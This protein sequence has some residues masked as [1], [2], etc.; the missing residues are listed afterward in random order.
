MHARRKSREQIHG[1]LYPRSVAVVGANRGRGTVPF[2][3]FYSILRDGFQGT[4]FPVSP[5]DKSIA[6]VKAYKYVIDIPDEI[7]MAVVVFPSTVAH[8]AMEQIGQKGIQS[9][10]IISAG[11]REIGKAGLE[12]EEEVRRIAERY[13]VSFIGPN[14]LGVINTDPECSF[15]A[16]F[17]RQMPAEGDIA[18]LSQSGAL[19]TAVLDYA[20]ARNIGFSKFVSLGNKADVTEIDLLRYLKDDPKTRVILLYLEEIAEGAALMETARSVITDAGKPVLILKSGRTRP[21]ASAAASH[22]GSLA[23]SDE[24]CDAAFRQAGIIRCDTIED[25][26]NYAIAMT[27]Q[28]LPAGNRVAIVTNAGGPGVLA[29]DRA[30]QEGLALAA[31]SEATTETLRKS[32][33]HTANLKN[34]VDIIGDAKKDR[35]SVALS[36]VLGDPGVDGALVIL[37]PQSMTD[38]RSIAEEICTISRR[39]AKPLYASFMGEADVAEGV[40]VLQRMHIP[41]YSLPEEMCEAFSRACLFGR[42]RSR[43]MGK[44][45]R[46]DDLRIEEVRGLVRQASE[47]GRRQLGVDVALRLVEACGLPVL[48]YGLA[49]SAEDAAELAGKIGFPVALKVASEAVVHKSDAGGVILGVG[50]PEEVQRGYRSILANVARSV[51][52]AEPEGVLVQHMGGGGEELILGV[53]KDPSFGPAILC[54]FG[55]LFV[56]LLRDIAMRMVPFDA[57]EARSM[58]EELRLYPLLAGAR[59]RQER[60]VESVLICIRRLCQLAQECEEIAELDI[61]P[62]IVR[63]QGQGCAVADARVVLG[64]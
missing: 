11:F 43:R 24:V 8:L 28:P 25:M 59:G 38:I 34:P 15:N 26:F 37:T 29:T 31:L 6:A 9:A 49:T 41:H 39:H 56:E 19:C 10:I 7:D 35:Y 44:I 18:F 32:L 58:L 64:I 27:Y 12:R 2:D 1:I 14:C 20:Q 45:E 22:T 21:G 61:N 53:R 55:G 17:A 3:I 40:E 46:F 51:P 60:D 54:G 30:V 42:L 50:T 48:D 62:L 36:S 23:G 47:Q 4:V 57:A 13:G 52:G 63:D 16:S 5:R 33:P